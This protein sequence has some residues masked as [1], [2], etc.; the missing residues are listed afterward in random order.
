M[1]PRGLAVF[2][3]AP[4]SKVTPVVRRQLFFVHISDL[5][6]AWQTGQEES[7]PNALHPKRW[8]IL[9]SR[10]PPAIIENPKC[11][12]TRRAETGLS[13][14][15]F[16]NGLV[17]GSAEISVLVVPYAPPNKASTYGVKRW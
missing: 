4:K 1:E 14:V 12:A 9:T 5:C 3:R 13:K 8:L 17:N 2:Y 6:Q 11:E 15:S 10:P 16:N 7:A